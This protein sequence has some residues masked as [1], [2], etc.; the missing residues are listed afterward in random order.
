MKKLILSLSILSFS[1]CG[2]SQMAEDNSAYVPAKFEVNQSTDN[3]VQSYVEPMK[4]TVYCCQS[5]DK[6]ISTENKSLNSQDFYK[7]EQQ[8]QLEQTRS[9]YQRGG[10]YYADRALMYGF[11][12]LTQTIYPF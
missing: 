5:K 9:L 12:V 7:Q 2:F 1:L 6:I 11:Q 8:K 4:D 10:N 3:Q